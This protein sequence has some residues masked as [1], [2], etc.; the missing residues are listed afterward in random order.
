MDQCF[1]RELGEFPGEAGREIQIEKPA[2][3]GKYAHGCDWAKERDWTIID[4]WRV[5][6]RPMRRVCWLRLGRMEWPAMIA[7][8]NKRVADYGGNA[9]HDKTGIGNVIDGYITENVEG[10]V[11]TGQRRSDVFTSYIAAIED[12]AIVSP[13]IA[14]CESEH[15]YCTNDDLSGSGHPPDSFVAGAM[16]YRASQKREPQPSEAETQGYMEYV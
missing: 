1:K 15:R 3:G 6:V 2:S 4:T 5:D 12:G 16:A 7:R 14:Y 13:R 10:V 11:L 9:C 8:F